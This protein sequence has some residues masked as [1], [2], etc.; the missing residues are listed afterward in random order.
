MQRTIITDCMDL[1]AG[2]EHLP[3]DDQAQTL[4]AVIDTLGNYPKP[5]HKGD[6]DHA[7]KTAL[8]AY[9]FVSNVRNACKLGLLGLWS[10]ATARNVA[11]SNLVFTLDLLMR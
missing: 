5:Q 2:F 11:Q 1:L 6:T 4:D 8:G 9:L 7:D 10:T 3:V